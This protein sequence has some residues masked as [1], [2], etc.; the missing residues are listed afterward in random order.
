MTVKFKDTVSAQAC[1]LVSHF[2][3]VPFAFSLKSAQRMDGRFFAGRRVE[4]SLFYGK[5][6]F[7]RSGVGE[8]EEGTEEERL[9]AF[10]DWIMADS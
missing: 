1:V 7:Q 6:R 4:A 5:Q 9:A 10:N 8:E 3:I 2:A